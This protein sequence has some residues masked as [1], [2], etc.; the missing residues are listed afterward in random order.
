MPLFNAAERRFVEAVGRM[1][2]C[3]PFS[4]ERIEC[5][6]VALGDAFDAAP[7]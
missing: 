4:P 1:A 2:H 6:R 3:N 7:G 5:E